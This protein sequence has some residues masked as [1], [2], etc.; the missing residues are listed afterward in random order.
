MIEK[1]RRIRIGKA[2]REVPKDANGSLDL[3]DV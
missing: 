1:V 2:I 3:E